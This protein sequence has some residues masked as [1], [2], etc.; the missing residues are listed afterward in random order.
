[1]NLV[2]A[3]T[4]LM[5]GGVKT[6]ALEH[7]FAAPLILDSRL[8]LAYAFAIATTPE[9][10][11]V[12]PTGEIAYRGRIDNRYAGPGVE[13]TAITR[14]DLREALTALLQHRKIDE[15]RTPA[16]GCALETP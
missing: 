2:Y 14:H 8:K 11:V 1:M 15:P 4:G 3:E 10:A 6:H 16:V 7:G 12:S 13:R 5:P 9:V